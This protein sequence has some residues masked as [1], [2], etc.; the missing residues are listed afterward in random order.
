MCACGH[1]PQCVYMWTW[2]PRQTSSVFLCSSLPRFWDTFH[3]PGTCHFGKTSKALPSSC[4]YLWA[5]DLEGY[6]TM[7]FLCVSWGFEP[8]PSMTHLFIP[9]ILCL[10]TS[11]KNEKYFVRKTQ[12]LGKDGWMTKGNMIHMC[13]DRHTHTQTIICSDTHTHRHSCAVTH[14]YTHTH[15]P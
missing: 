3:N 7:H 12:K 14:V 1:T 5:L 13:S 11:F 2:K 4:L 8:R 10:I 6:A 9:Q 15:V